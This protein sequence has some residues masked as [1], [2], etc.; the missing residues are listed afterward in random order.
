MTNAIT[1]P[2]V[3]G[4]KDKRHRGVLVEAAEGETFT[5]DK[6]IEKAELDWLVELRDPSSNDD[7]NVPADDWKQVVK[8]ELIPGETPESFLK[9][10]KTVGM[11]KKRYTPL[12]NRHAFRFFDRALIDKAAF[13]VAA[14][15]LDFGR[16]VYAIAKRPQIMELAPGDIVHEHLILTTSHDGSSAVKVMFAPY[17]TSTGTML[18]VGQGRRMKSMVK[19]R[20]TK[21]IDVKMQT[22]HNVLAAETDYFDRWRAALVGENGKGGFKSRV[23]T[24]DEVNRV[25]NTLFPS[26]KKKDEQ[27]NEYEETSGK[28]QKARDLIL[29][30]I[31][32]QEKARKEAHEKAQQ[33]TP[34]KTTALDLFLGVSEYAA[35]DRKA[36]NE[37]NN[38]VVSTFGSGQTLREEAFQLISGL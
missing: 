8:V 23:V 19:V 18:H 11:V 9:R 20:H 1:L 33:E 24:T 4:A 28:A 35:K 29:G 13:M 37:G 12:Q 16:V 25:V 21:S 14:G 32:E 31:A 38:W 34:G 30:R 6:I 10:F 5:T 22:L 27:G 7:D 36:K 3:F 17:R 2:F 26:R 15:H